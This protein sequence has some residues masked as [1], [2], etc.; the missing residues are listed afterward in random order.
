MY[1]CR[2]DR[3]YAR[4][5]DR[6]VE[7]PPEDEKEWAA[8]NRLADF[9][10]ASVVVEADLS[11]LSSEVTLD[12]RARW[13][14][15]LAAASKWRRRPALE[16]PR[17]TDATEIAVS[18]INDLV[19]S[20]LLYPIFLVVGSCIGFNKWVAWIL[21]VIFVVFVIRALV[22]E[23]RRKHAAAAINSEACPSCSYDLTG[24]PNVIPISL[25]GL[26]TGPRRCPEC[27]EPWPLV[28]RTS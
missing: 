22:V 5:V 17:W 2:E 25:V 27:G 21:A 28:P 10:A 11:R 1:S 16:S 26:P 14:P 13:H 7:A 15:I 8:Y 24:L 9:A 20:V 19:M 4:D 23:S 6:I 3:H 12:L 18:E